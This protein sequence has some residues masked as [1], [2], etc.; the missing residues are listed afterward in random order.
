MLWEMLAGRRMWQGATEV[1]IIDH[2]ASSRVM[3]LL[4]WDPE[5]PAG[6]DVICARALEP[7]PDLRYQ[8]AAQMEQDIASVLVGSADSHPRQL[9]LLVS[10]MF[11]EQRAERQ[12][13]IERY[14][15]EDDV[16]RFA[17]E[18]R[19][20]A[21]RPTTFD[22]PSSVSESEPMA[23]PASAPPVAAPR[24]RWRRAVQMSTTLVAATLLGVLVGGWRAE[25]ARRS[26]EPRSEVV[27][28][29]AV[30]PAPTSAPAAVPP[31]A[32]PPPSSALEP[33]PSR[34]RH[35]RR[36]A[37]PLDDDATLPPSIGLAHP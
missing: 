22:E 32:V 1:A 28:A 15:R 30:A 33:T 9:G 12:A 27:A 8:T 14:V 17:A 23:D 34:H 2:L 25:A 19:R 4:P 26:A 37:S 35:S 3:P 29:P 18:P 16:T 20:A 6:L 7:D 11:A 13:L 31:E 24:S 36:R 21:P 10:M 5:L